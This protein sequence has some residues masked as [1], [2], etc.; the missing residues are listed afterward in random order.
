M[1]L[2]EYLRIIKKNLNLF[3]AIILATVFAVF[4]YFVFRPESWSASLTLNVTRSGAQE[5]PDYK[6]DDFYRLQAD[7]KFAETVVEWLKSPRVAADIYEKAGIDTSNFSLRQLRKSI[8]AEKMS[9][10]IV[11]VS[12]SSPK[13]ET[14]QKISDAVSKIV[15]ENT[16]ALNKDQNEKVWFEII[17]QS[18]V[19]VKNSYSAPWVFL[20][21]LAVGIFLGF[22]VVMVKHYLK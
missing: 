4:A 10:Q 12:F 2:K 3:I 21:S 13:K 1:E 11:A 17:S 19:I 7:E 20:A 5:T 8:T 18:P 22:W 15:I 6:F 16:Q 14:S 9:S